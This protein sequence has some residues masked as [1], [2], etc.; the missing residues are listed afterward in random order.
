MRAAVYARYSSDMQREASI[1]DQVR[2]CRQRI[3]AEGWSL[4]QTYTDQ[5]MS[6]AHRLRPGYQR[7]LQDARD[8]QFDIVVAEA[9][10]RLS[11]DLEDIAAFHKQLCFSDVKIVTLAEGEIT[12]LH[13][14]MKG[15]MNA[16]FLKDLAAKTHRGLE[17]RVRQ[18]RSA[19]GRAYGYNVVREVDSSG[20]PVRGGRCIDEHEAA[21]VRRIF[22]AFATGKAPRAIA[23]E[24]NDDGIPGPRGRAWR[25]T[26]IRGHYTRRTG[27]INNELY[28]GRLV[29]NRQRYVKDPN[30][31]KR[32]SRPNPESEWIIEAVPELRIVDQALWE[33]VRERLSA[34]RS[35]PRSRKIQESQFWKHRRPKHL[36][37]GLVRCGMC[38]GAFT[39]VGRDYLACGVARG[40]GTC[41][42]T[43][44]I[45]R[46]E[47]ETLVLDGLKDRLME[48]EL[49]E[50]FIREFHKEINRQRQGR[51]GQTE[52]MRREL[53]QVSR[54]LDGLIDAIADGLRSEG[55][56]DTLAVQFGDFVLGD[57]WI[58]P[59]GAAE[60]SDV[61][62]L[63][64]LVLLDDF[65]V[66]PVD[67]TDD[68]FRWKQ[69]TGAEQQE[70]PSS[71]NTKT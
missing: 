49:V 59:D 39:S 68:A 15:T 10:D 8:G 3:D 36:L 46:G 29:W 67:A 62:Q 57:I 66:H 53:A 11:R 31:G 56:N 45:R 58:V 55:L 71:L 34:I 42:N 22:E 26:T 47:L 28:V 65:G 23:K 69:R 32:V 21:I 64:A 5:A 35:S 25:D 7:L 70:R 1:E 50:E 52:L 18:G 4:V 33:R 37:T 27:I 24:L 12:E 54:K 48:P 60:H 19:G 61:R 13:I 30:T 6:G 51:E 41:T 44:G 9:L 14:G 2:V 38:G 20:E 43:R 40:S 17:G 63:A 16:L